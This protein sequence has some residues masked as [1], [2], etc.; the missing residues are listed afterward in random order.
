MSESHLLRT[1][2]VYAAFA[3]GGSLLAAKV[4]VVLH[5][6]WC[7]PRWTPCFI[8][9]WGVRD[10]IGQLLFPLAVGGIVGL[11]VSP[12]ARGRWEVWLAAGVS[13]IALYHA[14][15]T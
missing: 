11:G 13:I 10:T 8:L 9:F 2:Y 6:P 1:V 5:D 4:N 3:A 7:T 14:V 12:W 15:S